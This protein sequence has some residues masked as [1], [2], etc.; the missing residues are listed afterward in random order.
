M[1]AAAA[2]A[3]LA[4]EVLAVQRL[5]YGKAPSAVTGIFLIF[6]SQCLGYGV[7]GLLRRTLVYPTKMLYPSNLPLNSLIETLHG[8]RSQVKKKLRVFY[9]GF[10]ALFVW[11]CKCIQMT[12][13]KPLELM[14]P[15]VFPEYIMPVLTGVSVFCLANRKSMLFTNMFGGSNGNEGLGLFSICLDW[16]YV[17]SSAMWLPL[18]T[19]CNN[20]FGYILC[21]AVFM[22]IYYG[23]VWNAKKV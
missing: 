7:A 5:Y 19:L 10:V 18:Q 14:K 3:P 16:Q 8:E 20:V 13:A 9:I 23:N 21:I 2:N 4:I 1:S 15:A 22:G 6:A 11:E 17:G 12:I